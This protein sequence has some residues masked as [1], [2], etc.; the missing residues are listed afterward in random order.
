MARLANVTH[1]DR[2][3]RRNLLEAKIMTRLVQANQRKGQY[4]QEKDHDIL[5]LINSCGAWQFFNHEQGDRGQPLL[6][7]KPLASQGSFGEHRS[8][9]GCRRDFSCLHRF[10]FLTRKQPYNT[11]LLFVYRP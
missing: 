7:S 3:V 6:V 8:A 4:D 1:S 11:S 2:V 10:A 9:D 5:F